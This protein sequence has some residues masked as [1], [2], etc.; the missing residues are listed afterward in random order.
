M[1]FTFLITGGAGFIG[2]HLALNL[3]R[4]GHAV[5]V[6]DNFSSRPRAEFVDL[7]NRNNAHVDIVDGDICDRDACREAV[8]SADYVLHHAAMASVPASIERPDECLKTNVIGTANL[9]E[10]A[11]RT[12]VCRRF[13]FA[14]SS[15]V[16]GDLL[17]VTKVESALLDPLSPYATSKLAGEHLSKNYCQIYGLPTVSLRYFNVYGE[18]QDPNGPYAAVIPRFIEAVTEN[19]DI[20]IYGDG[21]QSRDFVSVRDVVQANLRACLS[22]IDQVAGMSFNI[23][24]GRQMTL[25]GLLEVLS[26]ITGV[27]ITPNY[28]PPRAGDIKHSLADIIQAK[29]HLGYSPE[30]PFEDGLRGLLKGPIVNGS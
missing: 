29:Q 18:R 14:S 25:N 28:L 20:V 13:V 10:E 30:I 27:S 3:V 5:R 22:P 12:G 21:E 17:P 8:R 23:G 1:V 24:S 7:I 11:S 2:S 16:Y 19:K 6:L 15:A 4:D 26:S 9:L